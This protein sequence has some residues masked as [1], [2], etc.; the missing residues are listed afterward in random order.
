MAEVDI[1]PVFQGFRNKIGELV[2]YQKDGETFVRRNGRHSD[3]NTESQQDVRNTFKELTSIWKQI[4]GIMRKGWTE[5]AKNRKGNGYNAFIKDNFAQ[6][7]AGV[8]IELFKQ[9]GDLALLTFTAAPGASG[10][11]ECAFT[12]APVTDGRHLTIFAIR[13]IAEGQMEV[14]VHP[15]GADAASPI[16]VTGLEP[17]AAYDLYAVLTDAEYTAATQSSASKGAA[18]TA[19][20]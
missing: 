8:P 9:I 18:V 7:R 14:T 11:A 5:L 17:G 19:G 2:F 13:N 15:M 4:S 3:P 1:N 16:T 10:E 12:P 6:R 20:S